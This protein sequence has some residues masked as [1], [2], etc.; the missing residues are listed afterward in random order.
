MEGQVRVQ[1]LVGAERFWLACAAQETVRVVIDSASAKAQRMGLTESRIVRLR[2]QGA[3]LDPDDPLGLFV[4]DGETLEAQL[5]EREKIDDEGDMNQLEL[6]LSSFFDEE[7]FEGGRLKTVAQLDEFQDLAVSSSAVAESDDDEDDDDSGPL[8]ALCAAV[9]LYNFTPEEPDEI[10]FSVGDQLTVY[11][12]R[13]DGW[14][15]GGQRSGGSVGYFPG[16]RVREEPLDDLMPIDPVSSSEEEEESSNSFGVQEEQEQEMETKEPEEKEIEIKENDERIDEESSGERVTATMD[17]ESV[18]VTVDAGHGSP[19][20]IRRVTTMESESETRTVTR[21]EMETSEELVVV[22][23]ASCMGE[24][25]LLSDSKPLIANLDSIQIQPELP[26][27]SVS[28]DAAGT[29]L[30]LQARELAASQHVEEAVELLSHALATQPASGALFFARGSLRERQQLMREAL[31]DYSRALQLQPRH[32]GALLGRARLAQVAGRH[33]ITRHDALSALAVQECPEARLLA[34]AAEEGLGNNQEAVAQ[35][36]ALLAQTPDHEEAHVRLGRVLM[37]RKE[38]GAARVELEAALKSRPRDC[39]LL[40]ELGKCC[41]Q[42]EPSAALQHYAAA[43][44]SEPLNWRAWRALALAH[45]QRKEWREAADALSA[46]VH[47]SAQPSA[48]LHA[49]LAVALTRLHREA[50]AQLQWRAAVEKR[51]ADAWLLASFAASLK[52]SRHNQEAYD[53][54]SRSLALDDTQARLYLL[55]GQLAVALLRPV[56][57]AR[58]D[59]ER[60]L[61]LDPSNAAAKKAL[62]ELSGETTSNE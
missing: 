12:K 45:A 17:V 40:L 30:L 11:R 20:T 29:A 61:A 14:W 26:R 18:T 50:E 38:F 44:Q 56:Q 1:V 46:A 54:A 36:R 28:L 32:V 19:E 43:T 59:L 53:V 55:R 34:A 21:A 3:V 31:A 9:A 27:R 16:N 58:T 33:A 47:C 10:G 37:K 24:P 49:E 39:E 4:P 41:A 57:D 51:P 8:V 15:R 13:E 48:T 60:A 6:A 25:P 42:V 22:H 35:L 2:Y 5:H 62:D 7:L 52:T 23:R